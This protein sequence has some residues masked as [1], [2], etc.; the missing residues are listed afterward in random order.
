MKNLIETSL[1]E[2]KRGDDE[3][4]GSWYIISSSIPHLDV[5]LPTR[6]KKMEKDVFLK[7]ST[8]E[9]SAKRSS[10]DKKIKMQYLY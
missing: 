7:L 5:L 3:D 9:Y 10:N 6:S 2:T 8:I 4:F 1:T